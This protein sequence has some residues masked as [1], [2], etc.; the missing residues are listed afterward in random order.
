MAS[1]K[2][3]QRILTSLTTSLLDPPD[4]FSS[5]SSLQSDVISCLEHHALLSSTHASSQSLIQDWI[6]TV[7]S[8]L[9]SPSD[10]VL[11]LRLLKETLLQCSTDV[12]KANFAAW[13]RQL[14]SIMFS[15]INSFSS[16]SSSLHTLALQ[17][18]SSIIGTAASLPECAREM[19]A[20]DNLPQTV[21][22]LLNL[23][24][25]ESTLLLSDGLSCLIECARSFPGATGS[26]G[27][28]K[29]EKKSVETLQD[30]RLNDDE[31]FSDNAAL[32]FALLPKLGGAGV[33]GARYREA[34][35]SQFSLLTETLNDVV[36]ELF[37]EI[38]HLST[39]ADLVSNGSN[40]TK[41]T[42]QRL[43]LEPI[44]GEDENLKRFRLLSR[45]RV[46]MKCLSAM[47]STDVGVSVRIPISRIL[48]LLFRLCNVSPSSLTF[49]PTNEALILA[50]ILPELYSAPLQ[51]LH[52]LLKT[53]G[54]RLFN[55]GLSVNRLILQMLNCTTLKDDDDGGRT[56]GLETCFHKSRSSI[57][58]FF[59]SWLH[60]YPS[61][62][63]GTKGESALKWIAHILRDV[64]PPEAE[65]ATLKSNS[66]SIDGGGG[67]G[68]GV[69]K[70]R[71]KM[72]GGIFESS[73]VTSDRKINDSANADVCAS[74][75]KGASA[76]ILLQGRALPP[77][78]HKSLVEFAVPLSQSI[79]L[80][81]RT[82]L[83]LPIP[84]SDA[85]CRLALFDLLK[86]LVLNPC[87]K[88]P[89]PLTAASAIFRQGV[90][91]REEK[92]KRLCVEANVIVANLIHPRV[93]P[94]QMPILY[95]KELE[96][97]VVGRKRKFHVEE[98]AVEEVINSVGASK[99]S[100]GSKE[101][102]E[103]IFANGLPE[104]A[105]MEIP[106]DS[107]DKSSRTKDNNCFGEG[108]TAEDHDAE[109]L[110]EDSEEEVEI[111]EEERNTEQ[112]AVVEK[113]SPDQQVY[114]V[115][116]SLL[117][118]QHPDSFLSTDS[119]S[120]ASLKPRA[121]PV[122]KGIWTPSNVDDNPPSKVNPTQNIDVGHRENVSTNNLGNKMVEE[123]EDPELSAMLKDFNPDADPDPF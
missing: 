51:A 102:A 48:T 12:F 28:G 83:P 49:K 107:L 2:E 59:G 76:L 68:R 108:G 41:S 15:E 118:I 90:E 36:D 9:R 11:G 92:V 81:Q 121:S 94:V 33:G 105:S 63:T 5:S 61:I 30:S 60:V 52:V 19:T 4:K 29:L 109:M 72:K 106:M 65:K 111:R 16:S 64:K 26:I 99:A 10:R 112:Y 20:K 27:K 95:S 87:P 7:N 45:F 31:S 67:G 70:S 100:K 73:S 75:L 35:E 8:F 6:K 47:L 120:R 85:D 58:E 93:H 79:C 38:P 13:F 115:D 55:H 32:F 88:W 37:L 80:R 84:Y 78:I 57:Y 14:N 42:S 123:E 101:A 39:K 23:D 3:I 69:K 82:N 110:E 66:S 96:E 22:S 43:P 18:L 113:N 122:K 116:R 97:E 71:K 62:K 34:W 74:A 53:A 117:D 46:L 91:D 56:Y 24:S 77:E 114:D 119:A 54:N 104:D 21:I 1:S 50:A 40:A 25:K 44:R 86:S 103:G 17:C 98:E 89:P